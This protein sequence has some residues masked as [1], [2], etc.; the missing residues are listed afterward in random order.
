MCLVQSRSHTPLDIQYC[1]TKCQQ[2]RN[3]NMGFSSSLSISTFLV[4]DRVWGTVNLLWSYSTHERGSTK[5]IPTSIRG[6]TGV[7]PIIRQLP[8]FDTGLWRW[9]F[10][11]WEASSKGR[12]TVSRGKHPS[13]P[14]KCED[15]ALLWLQSLL[16]RFF[17]A[18]GE[19]NETRP[20]RQA[21]AGCRQAL[22][23]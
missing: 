10:G 6:T 11:C 17:R 14:T 12:I 1:L 2:S 15:R 16:R 5:T 22:M 3:E 23:A 8:P 18:R 19:K 13:Q 20:K 4:L 7:L 9:L 21:K